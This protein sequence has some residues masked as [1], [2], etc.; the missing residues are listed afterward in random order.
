M[1]ARLG[2]TALA[3]STTGALNTFMLL[4]L[5]MGVCFIVASFSS[6]LFGRGD[7]AGA[8]RYGYY[9]LAVA[10]IT[11]ALILAL[12]PVLGDILGAT[13]AFSPEVL[14]T[15][16]AY[17]SYRLL[18]GGAAVGF[19][20][21]SNYYGGLGNT[22]LPMRVSLLTMVSN[23]GFNAVFIFGLLGMPALGVTG[24]AIGSALSS[25][26]GFVVLLL[27][28]LRDGRAAGVVVP[29]LYSNEF[30]RMVRFGF[31]A[32]LNWFFELFAFIFFVNLVV[33]HLGTTTLAA[34][35]TAIEMNSVA[36]M[37]AFGI[38]SAG[39]ILVGQRIGAK[40]L[41]VVPIVVRRTFFL[42]AIWQLVVSTL[43]LLF[44]RTLFA[45]FVDP[46]APNSE[47]LLSTGAFVVMCSASWQLCDAAATTLAESLR[48]AGDTAFTM[49]TRLTIG[50][51]IF[52]PGSYVTVRTLD[53]GV[54]VAVVWLVVYLGLLAAV[55]YIR[56]RSGAWRRIELVDDLSPATAPVEGT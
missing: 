44:P 50:W 7:V 53:L 2:E 34:F 28:F 24:A 32:G 20:A 37:P 23:V 54:W 46:S 41:D 35:M 15:L 22:R 1:V 18:G 30:V 36:F 40:D 6:Q 48:A 33:A 3:A 31:P 38:A 56:F 26:L 13:A 52:V 29:K 49:W 8:R 14:A 43:Y 27:V 10:L 11:Q 5:P 39:A 45:A 17:M 21:L 25:S 47:A 51:A 55:L 42:S 16:T 9:G 4:I 19:E 12:R